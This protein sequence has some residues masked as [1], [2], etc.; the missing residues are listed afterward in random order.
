[1]GTEIMKVVY[2]KVLAGQLRLVT[3]TTPAGNQGAYVLALVGPGNPF[4]A[5]P[6]IPPGRVIGCDFNDAP[7]CAATAEEVNIQIDS[8][9]VNPSDVLTQQAPT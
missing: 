3:A 7:I 5:W 9:T 2:E 4:W 8:I 1:M 6:T